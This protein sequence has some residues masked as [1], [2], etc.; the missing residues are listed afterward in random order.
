M[1]PMNSGAAL[2]GAQ[3]APGV[4]NTPSAATEDDVGGEGHVVPADP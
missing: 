2:H 3:G 4:A 1:G